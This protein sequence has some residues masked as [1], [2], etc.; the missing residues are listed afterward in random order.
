V[1]YGAR[2][3]LDGSLNGDAMERPTDDY[4]RELAVAAARADNN[5]DVWRH[6]ERRPPAWRSPSAA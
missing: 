3:A 5:T 4:Q 1:R 6:A 2:H